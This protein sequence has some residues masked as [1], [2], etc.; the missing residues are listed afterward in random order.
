MS[1]NKLLFLLPN[2]KT[3]SIIQ[4]ELCTLLQIFRKN[5][6]YLNNKEE[7]GRCYMKR[8]KMRSIRCILTVFLLLTSTVGCSK[9][10][11]MVDGNKESAQSQSAVTTE[12]DS[13]RETSI[14]NDIGK[15][16]QTTSSE[17]ETTT[18]QQET[19]TTKQEIITTTCEET[20]TKKQEITTTK[21]QEETTTKKQEETTTKK[22]NSKADYEETLKEVTSIVNSIIK[23]D[24][25]DF[26]KILAIHDW[27]TFN[28]D[29]DFTYS[30][31]YVHE[32]LEDGTA[33]CQ[34]YALTFQMMAQI[35]GFECIFVGGEATNSAGQ[36]GGHAWNQI[37]M[38]GVWYN[39]DTTWDDPATQGKDKNNHSS[40]RYDYFLVS[41]A[42]LDKNHKALMDKNPCLYDYDK[43]LILKAAAESG[44]HKNVRYADSID[45]G[46][47]AVEAAADSGQTEITLWYYDENVT[48]N[49]M[50]DIIS[51][52]I[53]KSS[54]SVKV[55]K[56]YYPKNNLTRYILN[57]S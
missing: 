22:T 27:I 2:V 48:K 53:S 6:D 34:G 36:T 25:T 31:F 18:T 47:A 17:Q 16:E 40:N 19:T 3:K 52:I 15:T 28:I 23:P 37:K 29:Y 1:G 8:N 42:T 57:I 24:M 45:S 33:V 46:I 50:R 51:K 14:I 56:S 44:V 35:L 9:S 49:N 26:Q 41:D 32:T 55:K 12:C 38:D 4:A 11:N 5:T 54:H 43:K 21:K 39:V 20:T 7:S 10:D 13:S 30:N